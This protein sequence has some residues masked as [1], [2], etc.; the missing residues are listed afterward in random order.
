[1]QKKDTHGYF[2]D[3]VTDELVSCC[4]WKPYE[5]RWRWRGIKLCKFYNVRPQAPGYSAVIKRPMDFKT[6]T[7]RFEKGEYKNWDTLQED[8]ETIFK[9]AMTFNLPVTP[10]HKKVGTPY[11][12]V[13]SPGVVIPCHVPIWQRSGEW[14]SVRHAGEDVVK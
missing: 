1:M 11:L 2:R 12:R 9:N 6:M 14:S 10:Y 5:A 3:P 4:D 13:H 7:A 8:L